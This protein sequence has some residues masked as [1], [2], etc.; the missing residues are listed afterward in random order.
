MRLMTF[1]V[2]MQVNISLR[3]YT[4]HILQE[5][6]TVEHYY[7]IYFSPN[8][9]QTATFIHSFYHQTTNVKC[10]RSCSIELSIV[11]NV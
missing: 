10:N 3:L 6:E 5:A 7:T 8:F 4:R 2:W 9:D 1:N 11:H